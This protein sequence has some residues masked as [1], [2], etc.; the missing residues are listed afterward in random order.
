[1]RTSLPVSSPIVSPHVYALIATSRR[2]KEM[3]L[4]EGLLSNP[5]AV[6]DYRETLILQDGQGIRATLERT[7]WIRFLQNGVSGI[8]DHMWGDGVVTDYDH[9]AGGLE[10]SF[11]DAG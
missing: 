8:L 5:Y 7:Q 1:M 9:E 6:L 10:D 2:L 11:N 3:L 4:P